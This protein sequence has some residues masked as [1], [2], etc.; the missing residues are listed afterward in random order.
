MIYL[1]RKSDEDVI[2]RVVDVSFDDADTL[3]TATLTILTTTTPPLVKESQTIAGN[4]LTSWWSGGVA[5]TDYQI[6]VIFTTQ[7]GRTIE[8][9]LVLPVFQR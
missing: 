6:K 9:T 5:G 4:K 3:L 2:D 1:L 7:F 8:D